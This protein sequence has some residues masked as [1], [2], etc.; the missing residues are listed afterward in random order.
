MPFHFKVSS[1]YT[2]LSDVP[3]HMI[4][5]EMPAAHTFEPGGTCLQ[6]AHNLTVVSA[7]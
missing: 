3:P 7:G 1:N 5:G 4:T 2:V 6:G